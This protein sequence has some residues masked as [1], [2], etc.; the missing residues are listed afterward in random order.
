VL[1][2]G[3]DAHDLWVDANDWTIGTLLFLLAVAGFFRDELLLQRINLT[4][5]IWIFVSPWIYG[6]ADKRNAA[7]DHWIV[8]F[9]VVAFAGWD[10]L[11]VR[12]ISASQRQVTPAT[13]GSR[14]PA[15][16]I[17]ASLSADVSEP[18]AFSCGSISSF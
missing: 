2:F 18:S 9:L 11:R 7:W 8:G 10:L 14:R 5:G 12:Q 3:L 6:F 1:N 17:A 15:N 16:C 4:L 13:S